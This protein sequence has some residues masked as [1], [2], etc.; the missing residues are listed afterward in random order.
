[1]LRRTSN[2]NE[3]NSTSL[4]VLNATLSHAVQIDFTIAGHLKIC[5]KA[6]DRK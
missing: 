6:S 3:L 1:M 4:A 2:N 5:Q